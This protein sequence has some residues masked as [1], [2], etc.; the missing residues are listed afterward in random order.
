MLD[1]FQ[2]ALSS[3]TPLYSFSL[4]LFF[5]DS[6]VRTSLRVPRLIMGTNPTAQIAQIPIRTLCYLEIASK[7]EHLDFSRVRRVKKSSE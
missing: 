7:V 6:G 5:Y 2:L 4:L 3:T 1:V